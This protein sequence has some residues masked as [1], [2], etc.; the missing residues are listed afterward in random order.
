M[1]VADSVNLQAV[2]VV[3]K[4]PAQAAA[5]A[6]SPRARAGGRAEEGVVAE[7]NPVTLPLASKTRAR[8]NAAANAAVVASAAGE[9][10]LEGVETPHQRGIR[11][12]VF[13]NKPDAN[14]S[15]PITDPHY[16]G[17]I[18]LVPMRSQPALASPQH[19]MPAH[20]H[21]YRLAI[22]NR[23]LALAKEGEESK[24]TVVP[25]R[26]AEKAVGVQI[27]LKSAALVRPK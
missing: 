15:T 1:T 19:S 8:A 7:G 13:V 16:V 25:V 14:A 10:H 20:A 23:T 6:A 2:N 3:Y 18:F 12:R 5:A 17:T 11:L 21:N 22:S 27:K 9:L 24:V 4:A 26:R